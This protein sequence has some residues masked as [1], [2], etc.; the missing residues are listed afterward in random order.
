MLPMR[1]EVLLFDF[2]RKDL[3]TVL[4]MKRIRCGLFP[5]WVAFLC[6]IQSSDL[7]AQPVPKI[8]GGRETES[9]WP[10]MAALIQSRFDVPADGAFCGGS[11]IHPQ[12]VL[13]AAH[14]VGRQF[15][16]GLLDPED[17]HVVVGSHDLDNQGQGM[18]IPVLEIIV[19]PDYNGDVTRTGN[20]LA[21]LLLAWPVDDAQPVTLLDD[22]EKPLEN[23]LATSIGWGVVSTEPGVEKPSILREASYP[24]VSNASANEARAYDGSLRSSMLPA[25]YPKGRVSSCYGDSGGPLMIQDPGTGE[26]LQVGI[27][28]FGHDCATPFSYGI[29]TRVT[30]FVSWIYQHIYPSFAAWSDRYGVRGLPEDADH[31]G[32]SHFQEFAFGS[33]PVNADSIP[34]IAAQWVPLPD[35]SGAELLLGIKAPLPGRFVDYRFLESEDLESWH[36]VE[37]MSVQGAFSERGSGVFDLSVSLGGAGSGKSSRF[38]QVQPVFAQA[39]QAF[40]LD[41][42]LGYS[43]NG[44]VS[45]AFREPDSVD[46]LLAGRMVRRYRLKSE[47]GRTTFRLRVSSKDFLPGLDV[48]H[49]ITNQLLVTHHPSEPVQDVVLTVDDLGVSDLMVS[50][51][52]LDGREGGFELASWLMPAERIEPGQTISSMLVENDPLTSNPYGDHLQTDSYLLSNVAPGQALEIHATSVPIDIALVILDAETGKIVAEDDDSGEGLNAALILETESEG[53]AWIVQVTTSGWHDLGLYELEI[54]PYD[55]V[56]LLDR[57]KLSGTLSPGDRVEGVIDADDERFLDDFGEILIADVYD[58]TGVEGGQLLTIELSSDDFDAYLQLV[59]AFTSQIIE[60]NDDHGLTSHSRIDYHVPRGGLEEPARIIVSGSDQADRGHYTLRVEQADVP[61]QLTAPTTRIA[62][63]EVI[64]GELDYGDN[65]YFDAYTGIQPADYYLLEVPKEGVD[66]EIRL[67]S[68]DFDAHL[69]LLDAEL[70]IHIAVNDDG[71]DGGP[72]AL[73]EYSFEAS[74]DVYDVLIEVSSVFAEDLGDY[75]LSVQKGAKQAPIDTEN[76]VRLLEMQAKVAGAVILGS[77]RLPGGLLGHQYRVEMTRSITRWSVVLESSQFD[78]WLG[79]SGSRDGHFIIEN[80]FY[81]VG[82]GTFDVD[83]S[84]LDFFSGPEID[85]LFLWV[86]SFFED[87]TGEYGLSVDAQVLP[88]IRIGKEIEGNLSTASMKDPYYQV[89]GGEFFAEDYALDSVAEPNPLRV[90]ITSESFLPEC[91]LMIP[92]TQETVAWS[93]PEGSEGNQAS[94]LFT[95]QEGMSYVLRVTSVQ[96]NQTGDYRVLIQGDGASKGQIE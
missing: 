25:G 70:G 92:P 88:L 90:T 13:T 11:L 69:A 5:V 66:V 59:D 35:D 37:P 58:L 93:L 49:P 60:Y 87:E 1:M 64:E 67:R 71:E 43:V 30:S 68:S 81:E 48:Y 6:L 19:H 79:L 54:S 55:G 61:T 3:L 40:A 53:Q 50:V 39:A 80:D 78:T 10:W 82:T 41:L 47:P 12:W 22:P 84:R 96:E 94:F 17:L 21:L 51:V 85:P 86:S 46:P 63:G 34:R 33:D 44:T 28:S 38:Y 26:W 74:E 65:T 45:N 15:G 9:E 62:I 32:W 42:A 73:I 16:L 27:V 20:D 7:A 77:D 91:Y 8:V 14:C 2:F 52:S 23:V 72:N 4:S 24:I 75:Q 83:R 36:A 31:D 76:E 57:T 56:A 89:Y 18:R 29:Y 95:P